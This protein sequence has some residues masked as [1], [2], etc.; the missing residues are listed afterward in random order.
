MKLTEQQLEKLR[1]IINANLDGDDPLSVAWISDE[2][3]QEISD[4]I[5]KDIT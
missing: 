1:E 5:E 2:G 3:L 4:F